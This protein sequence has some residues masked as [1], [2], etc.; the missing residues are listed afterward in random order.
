MDGVRTN[1]YIF[2]NRIYGKVDNMDMQVLKDPNSRIYVV[3][4]LITVAV[5]TV[6]TVVSLA[7][8]LVFAPSEYHTL[9]EG[10]DAVGGWLVILCSAV[11]IIC[12]ALL[13]RD[14]VRRMK[15]CP[16]DLRDERFMRAPYSKAA[17]LTAVM[18][19]TSFI[20]MFFSLAIGEEISED[21][22]DKMSN[23]EIM[24]SMITAGPTEEGIFRVV[25]IGVPMFLICCLKHRGSKKDILGGFGMSRAALVLIIISSVLFGAA[26]LDG[27]SLMKF[28]DT[29]IAGLLFGYV[30]VQYGAHVTIFM[31]S[32][33]DMMVSFDI[34]YEGLATVPMAVLAVLGTVLLI[35]S[36]SDYRRYLPENNLHE[37]FDG[38]LIEMWE[39]D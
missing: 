21:F 3:S 2:C 14:F 1:R 18:I 17:I 39:R 12:F 36:I 4:T 23:Y 9:D 24:A 16:A 5:M 29:F 33:F 20:V 30:Y 19:L 35:R 6:F 8:L 34:F 10:E 31:H 25:L 32:A 11:F 15:G 28:P 22:T 27:W 7:Y 26:H 13:I 37:P 38:T